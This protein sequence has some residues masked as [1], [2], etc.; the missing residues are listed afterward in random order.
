MVKTTSSQGY[1]I[2]QF[3]YM[4]RLRERLAQLEELDQNEMPLAGEQARESVASDPF[5]RMEEYYERAFEVNTQAAEAQ[6]QLEGKATKL[7]S[8]RSDTTKADAPPSLGETQPTESSDPFYTLEQTYRQVGDG[9][10]DY[11]DKHGSYA[12]L[13]GHSQSSQS[14]AHPTLAGRTPPADRAGEP[15]SV[16]SSA[17][18]PAI[19]SES[20]ARAGHSLESLLA[21]ATDSEHPPIPAMSSEED[22]ISMVSGPS[23]DMRVA[24]FSHGSAYAVA[25]GESS[26]HP[27]VPSPEQSTRATLEHFSDTVTEVVR[28]R[29]LR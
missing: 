15:R 23:S 25:S 10:S 9:W 26:F 21:M 2:E 4:N 5:E 3:E 11:R 14:A 6:A 18:R 20:P 27:A 12:T 29:K 1:R 16:D 17:P 22:T 28:Q 7:R 19:D 24:D 8:M 13:T